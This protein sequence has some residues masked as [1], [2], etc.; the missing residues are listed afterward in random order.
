ML[1]NRFKKLNQKSQY[2]FRRSNK[3]LTT[4]KKNN[5][6]EKG[7][8]RSF[9]IGNKSFCFKK[10]LNSSK[11]NINLNFTLIKKQDD[12]K[13]NIKKDFFNNKDY[14]NVY[15]KIFKFYPEINLINC[16]KFFREIYLKNLIDKLKNKEINN[17]NNNEELSIIMEKELNIHKINKLINFVNQYNNII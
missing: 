13:K 1:Q 11:N 2:V 3:R 7:L 14:I 12:N 8:N 15:D 17:T 4:I 9:S 6:N 10:K 16:N 5:D